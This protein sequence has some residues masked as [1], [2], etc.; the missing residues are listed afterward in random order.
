V[1]RLLCLTTAGPQDP[2]R[3]SIPVHLAAN[4]A[5][6]AGVDCG[7]VLAGDAAVLIKAEAADPVVGLGVPPLRDLIGKLVQHG[8]P[9]Y[10]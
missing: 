2:T 1:P 10:V 8:V 9:L 7:L 5:V 6:E 3:A 4:G